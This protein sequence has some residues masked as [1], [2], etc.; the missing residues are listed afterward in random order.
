[1]TEFFIHHNIAK[2]D[3]GCLSNW[4]ACLKLTLLFENIKIGQI[5]HLAN[6]YGISFK[7]LSSS[8]AFTYIKTDLKE[9]R[10]GLCLVN[11]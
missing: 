2:L 5:C 11:K 8:K 3:A 7:I 4:D 1:M 10:V 6:G 9:E